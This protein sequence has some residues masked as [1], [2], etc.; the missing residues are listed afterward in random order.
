MS[1]VAALAVV[2]LQ[3]AAVSG[4]VGGASVSVRDTT[5][6]DGTVA[7]PDGRLYERLLSDPRDPRFLASV[8]WVSAP[9]R[10]TTVGAVALGEEVGIVRWNGDELGTSVQLGLSAGVF[11]QFDLRTPSMNL[12]NADYVLGIP[13]TMRRDRASARIRIYHQSSHLGDEFL[14]TEA[15][16]RVNLS[17]ESLEA[18]GSLRV[19]DGQP[20][21]VRLY[22]GGEYLV[23]REPADLEPGILHAGI[24][25]DQIGA[26]FRA[27]DLGEARLIAG[28]DV[29][30]WE[31][32]DWRPAWSLR[33]GLEFGPPGQ[34]PPSGRGFSLL[35]ELYDGPSPYGQF[36]T[37]EIRYAGVGLHFDL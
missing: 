33:G 23:R 25:A 9:R 32:H 26:L 13:L 31:H 16:E 22:G 21:G 35:I 17:F 2:V 18:L 3:V 37:E 10:A 11:A 30:V 24:E 34:R 7:F 27:S 36:L 19:A 15:P 28:L 20:L 1:T 6:T 12:M 29:R 14:L 4:P 8:L 5:G